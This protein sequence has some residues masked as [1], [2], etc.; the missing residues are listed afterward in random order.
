MGYQKKIAL[1]IGWGSV[2]CAAALGLLRVLNQEGITVDMMVTS[3]GG[4]IFGALFALGYDVE[5]IV[6]MNQRLWTHEV[7]DQTNRLAI[8]QIFFPKLFRVKDYFNLRSDKLVNQKLKEAMGEYTF[9]DTK[10]PLYISATDYQTGQQVVFSEGSIYEAVRATIALPLIFPPFRKEDRLLADGYLSEPLPVG[11]AIQEG[12]D[13]ILAM[14]FGAISHAERNSFSDYILH[15]SSILSHNLLQAAYSFYNVAHHSDLITIVP[16]FE[17]DIQMFDTHKVPQIIQAGEAEAKRI[18][19]EL[20]NML[21][22][23]VP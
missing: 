23:Q 16:Q 7:T 12:A 9:E 4:S 11:T 6:E 1:V 14:G 18:L 20:K 3:G 17:D 15:L 13:I 10:I 2:K 8:L 19:P 22:G 21:I 5:E